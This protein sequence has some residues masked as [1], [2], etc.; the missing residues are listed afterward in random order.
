MDEL[1]HLTF[2]STN[3]A[4]ASKKSNF[5][6]ATPVAWC[7]EQNLLIAR[8][9]Q[10]NQPKDGTFLLKPE[11]F[12]HPFFPSLITLAPAFAPRGPEFTNCRSAGHLL[13]IWWSY[14]ATG[15]SIKLLIREKGVITE[16]VK[17]AITPRESRMNALELARS[18][19]RIFFPSWGVIRA[20]FSCNE[21]TQFGG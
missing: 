20:Y 9:L 6:F 18:P 17:P 11:S 4:I 3:G 12:W 19:S 5:F 2:S 13:T 21:N 7:P 15:L 8:D 10:L 14:T 16:L 1:L